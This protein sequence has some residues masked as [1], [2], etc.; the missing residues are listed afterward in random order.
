[1]CTASAAASPRRH[2]AC[3]A[4]VSAVASAAASQPGPA[5]A[6]A[7]A[8][9]ADAGTGGGPGAHIGGGSPFT[10]SGFAFLFDYTTML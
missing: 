3:S 10:G 7:T 6:I 9:A 2:P 5:R 1:M 8:C 4:L